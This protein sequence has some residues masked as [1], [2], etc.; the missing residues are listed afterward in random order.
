VPLPAGR[1]RFEGLACGE[2]IEATEE[3]AG[4]GAGLRI[5]GGQRSQAVDREGEWTALGYEFALEAAATVELV[6]ELR[7]SAGTVSFNADSLTLLRLS[8]P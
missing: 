3:E 8:Q 7:A 4:S 2:G 6:A 5:S 1:Y